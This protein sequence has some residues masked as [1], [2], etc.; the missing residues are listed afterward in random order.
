[1]KYKAYT[2]LDLFFSKS[3]W[4]FTAIVDAGKVFRLPYEDSAADELRQVADISD[5]APRGQ[6]CYRDSEAYAALLARLNSP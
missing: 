1:M 6:H 2:V 3:D 5:D 4:M